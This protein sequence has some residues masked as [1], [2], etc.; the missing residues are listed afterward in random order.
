MK[1][2]NKIKTK[3]YTFRITPEQQRIITQLREDHNINIS[4]YLSEQ[5]QI[6]HHNI[7]I[8]ELLKSMSNEK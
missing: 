3:S 8:K 6:L 4:E 5:L 2:K 1:D 7:I